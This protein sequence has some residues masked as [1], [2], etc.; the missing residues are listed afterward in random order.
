MG[1]GLWVATGSKLLRG[2][3]CQGRENK[4]DGPDWMFWRWSL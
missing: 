4:M 2:I 1:S 3:A